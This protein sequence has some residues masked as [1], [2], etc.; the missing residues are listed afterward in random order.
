MRLNF[1]GRQ[2]QAISPQEIES[3]L[4]QINGGKA[5][6]ALAHIEK[7]IRRNG[8]SKV[9]LAL[10]AE[11]LRLSGDLS[12]AIDACQ[13]AAAAGAPGNWLRAGQ[14]LAGERRPDEAFTCLTKAMSEDPTNP[15][16]LDAIITTLFNSG[17]NAQGAFFAR[18]LLVNPRATSEQRTRAALLLSSNG[19]HDE[20]SQTL[21][22]IAT[23]AQI[24]Q[25]PSIIGSVLSSVHFTCDWTF[26][27]DLR[28]Q[29]T[30]YYA[31]GQF[32]CTQE[33]PLT[34]IAWCNNE[35]F[36]LGVTQAYAKRT[37]PI[38]E[39]L[40]LPSRT[41]RDRLRV[42]YLSNDFRNH[43]T[44]HLMVGLFERH[45]RRNFEIFAYDYSLPDH[46]EYRERFL[47]AI[48]HH[49]DITDLTDQEAAKRICADDLDLLI[50]LKGHTGL[51]R[52]AILAYRPAPVQASYLGFPGSTGL[53]YVDY[54]I[55]DQFV[56]PNSCVNYYPER[57][58]RLPHSYQCN[59]SVQEIAPSLKTRNDFGL[60]DDK[61]VFCSFNQAYKID[62]VSFSVWLEILL[63]VPDSVLWLLVDQSESARQ[64]LMRTAQEKGVDPL[65]LIFACA[66]DPIAHRERLLFADIAL[67]TL[68]CNGHT[69]TSDMLRWGGAPVVTARGAHFASRVSESLLNAMNLSELVGADHLDMVK[70]ACRIGNDKS[71]RSALR[72][73]IAESRS[74]APLFDATQFTL[75]FERA[76]QM[77]IENHQTQ[78]PTRILDVPTGRVVRGASNK[79]RKPLKPQDF[80]DTPDEHFSTRQ[81][82]ATQS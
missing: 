63:G 66:V 33:Y 44:L 54:L 80:L 48:E 39:P 53:P 35:A 61:V 1:E 22:E 10:R 65:R 62:S 72:E 26:L 52:P 27:D 12:G 28:A 75:D 8:K 3:L 6:I 60:P 11:A 45:D 14:L 36:N 24:T 82:A 59:D 13:L 68:I 64:N 50:D 46:S 34:N 19:L 74:T 49:V 15:E 40:V 38:V 43:A 5:R 41:T 81:I 37:I 20:A 73:K 30:A 25:H 2:E 18:Y 77:M 29:A 58:C 47:G 56:T 55:T 9:L 69:T 67:D 7:R 51:S 57:L 71:Y 17:R 79:Q 23:S 31:Q 21:K 76:I 32:E 70:I 78:S 42:G 16:P 4:A